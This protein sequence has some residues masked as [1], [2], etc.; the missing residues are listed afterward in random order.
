M[1]RFAQ[2]V[3]A[4]DIN[5]RALRFVRMNAA[6]NGLDNIE[7]AEGD[8]LEPL[9]AETFDLLVS[10]PPFVP[11]PPGAAPATY[12]LGGPLGT[13]LSEQLLASAAS[14]LTARGRATVVFERPVLLHD[15]D[16][17]L[18]DRIHGDDRRALVLLGDEVNAD[19]YSVRYA[20]PELRHRD[21]PAFEDGVTEMRDH[22][23]AVGIRGVQPAVGV[24]ERAPE[25]SG[26]TEL[27]QLGGTLWD[28]LAPGSVDRLVA[29]RDLLTRPLDPTRPVAV[30]VPEG[31][32]VV[33]R[34][35]A[36]NKDGNG[37]GDD[38]RLILPPGSPVRVLEFSRAE[39]G[40]L[41][42]M[43]CSP[44]DRGDGAVLC[45]AAAQAESEEARL[46][47]RLVRAGLV[48]PADD[49][50]TSD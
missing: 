21:L 9:G 2:R 19:A 22:L 26:W 32:M 17:G 11:C 28:N 24:V 7:V 8:L 23:N 27:V 44:D 30:R 13:E 1:S 38:V 6:L 40:Q 3:L 45:R 39:W 47:T 14:H 29:A 35:A 31:S 46:L 48:D 37:D 42:R 49:P 50:W 43:Q 41:Q 12:R 20:L 16:D 18:A 25:S 4:T 10:Q 33:H 36:A 34:F 15:T 5:P